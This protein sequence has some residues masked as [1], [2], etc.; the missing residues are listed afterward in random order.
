MKTFVASAAALGLTTAVAA[1]ALAGSYAPAPEPAPVTAPVAMVAPSGDWGGLYMGAQLGY[2][3]VDTRLTNGDDGAIGGLHVGYRWDFGQTVAGTELDYDWTDI[4]IGD[5]NVDGIARLKGTLGYDLGN[6]LAYGVVG[7]GQ[8][9]SS[10]GDAEGWL[11][12]VGLAYAVNP[13]WIVS[14]EVLYQDFDEFG[15][16]GAGGHA[17]TAT[18]R[19]SY[20]F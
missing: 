20:R 14:G 15:D 10:A 13:K 1:P 7:Y 4:S 2:G 16:T 9:D 5:E 12:G 3:H 18:I 17:T 6:T 19:A 11:G 8:A